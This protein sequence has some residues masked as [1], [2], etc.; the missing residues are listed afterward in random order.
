MAD[1]LGVERLRA[2]R[3]YF[4][5]PLLDSGAMLAECFRLARGAG[6]LLQWHEG[7][8]NLVADAIIETLN[9]VP[10]LLD[11]AE[12]RDTLNRER[13]MALDE[14]RTRGIELEHART[15]GPPGLWRCPRCNFVCVHSTMNAYDGSITANLDEPEPCPN[16]GEH[17]N[18]V[19]WREHAIEMAARAEEQMGM[20]RVAI[21]ERDEARAQLDAVTAERDR[22][23]RFESIMEQAR[24]EQEQYIRELRVQ[25]EAVTKERDRLL[26]ERRMI[27][28]RYPIIADVEETRG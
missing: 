10:A 21:E 5:G 19:T 4:A 1:T 18:R 27:A 22:A 8:D 23:Q 15:A 11:A 25:L 28:A 2:L 12:E 9:H 24:H 14:C 16:D 20:A 17:L 13:D 7:Y 26:A 3:E 6:H